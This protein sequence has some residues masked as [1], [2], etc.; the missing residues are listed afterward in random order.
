MK[1]SSYL[2][3]IS[4][5]SDLHRDEKCNSDAILT[6]LQRSEVDLLH[7]GAL[8]DMR[9]TEYEY[10][11]R[12]EVRKKE[13]ARNL[14]LLQKMRVPMSTTY[15]PYPPHTEKQPSACKRCAPLTNRQQLLKW[16]YSN[17]ALW[18]STWQ[19]AKA[20]PLPT[21][22]VLKDSFLREHEDDLCAPSPSA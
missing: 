3:V 14:S 1:Q 10:F 19:S 17:S 5:V 18:N 16:V 20:A 22:V 6:I 11:T 9:R 7:S 4:E 2:D 8:K 13:R 21:D 12:R 15:R